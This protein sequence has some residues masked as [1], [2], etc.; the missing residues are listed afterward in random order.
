MYTALE[1]I[2]ILCCVY[3]EAGDEFGMMGS[4]AQPRRNVIGQRRRRR[5]DVTGRQDGDD[6]QLPLGMMKSPS[7]A[8]DRNSSR[9]ERCAV[10]LN[11]RTPLPAIHHQPGTS[12]QRASCLPGEHS[13]LSLSRPRETLE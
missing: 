13:G 11:Q 5:R 4:R 9:D 6:S 12:L 8:D 7:I 1:V 10:T 3:T 2:A